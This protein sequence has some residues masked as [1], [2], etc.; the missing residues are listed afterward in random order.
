MDTTQKEK[1]I[2]VIKDVLKQ[3]LQEKDS[4]THRNDILFS[5]K[6]IIWITILMWM[7]CI[8]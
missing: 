5:K 4:G 6:F 2:T 8:C 3:Y 1:N 7:I